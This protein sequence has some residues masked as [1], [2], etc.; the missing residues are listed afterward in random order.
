[1]DLTE[2]RAGVWLLRSVELS[3]AVSVQIEVGS[4][5]DSVVSVMYMYD[6]SSS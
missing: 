2:N 1:M 5:V 4:P 6:R 3:G